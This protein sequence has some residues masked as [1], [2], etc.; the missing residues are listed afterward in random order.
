MSV[1]SNL[2]SASVVAKAMKTAMRIGALSPRGRKTPAICSCRSQVSHSISRRPAL[3][4]ARNTEMIRLRTAASGVG[5]AMGIRKCNLDLD[6]HHS[7][8][9]QVDQRVRQLEVAGQ[10]DAVGD[11]AA[12]ETDA[13]ADRAVVPHAR[14]VQLAFDD[15]A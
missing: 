8:T 1:S 13:F 15:T 6:R 12:L 2:S 4:C 14:V 3:P 10:L 11:D 7:I 9:I 5:V